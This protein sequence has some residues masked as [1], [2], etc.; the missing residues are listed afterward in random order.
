MA[1]GFKGLFIKEDEPK[2]EEAPQEVVELTEEVV[3]ET[4]KADFNFSY[5]STGVP[6]A[7]EGAVDE[8]IASQLMAGLEEAKQNMAYFDFLKAKQAMDALP[9]DEAAKFQATF[10]SLST[11]GLTQEGLVAS[12]D[13]HLTALDGELE[14]FKLAIEAKKT[15]EITSREESVEAN[16]ELMNAKAEQI[17]KLTEEI[18]EIQGQ[19]TVLG[20]EIAA[21]NASIQTSLANFEVTVADV[22]SGIQAHKDQVELY[23]SQGEKTEETNG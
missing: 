2:K 5:Q 22:K 11:Q 20:E 7:G 16:N 8:E 10:V 15:Q 9:L 14:G 4:P 1:G 13:E 6:V 18:Q 3:E 21:E 23:L 17:Q 12:I 19:N